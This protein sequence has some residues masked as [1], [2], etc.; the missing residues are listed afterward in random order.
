MVCELVARNFGG[1]SV[2]SVCREAR[3]EKAVAESLAS[4]SFKDAKV[5]YEKLV[6]KGLFSLALDATAIAQIVRWRGNRIIGYAT[7]EDVRVHYAQDIIAF[8]KDQKYGEA[9]Q[10]YAFSL[11]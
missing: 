1:P 8:V 4:G 9:C 7:N 10:A 5:F 6:S 2:S 11:L 3:S